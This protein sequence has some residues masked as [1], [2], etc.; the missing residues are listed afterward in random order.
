MEGMVCVVMALPL[1]LPLGCLGGVVGCSIAR[2]DQRSRTAWVASIVMLPGG[3]AVEHLTSLPTEHCVTTEIVVTATPETVWRNVIR[4]PDLPPPTEAMFRAGISCPMGAAIT[5]TGVGAE[6]RCLFTTG[7]F[8][9]PIT[10]WD[11]P[12]HLAFDV[13]SQPEPMFEMTPFRHVHPPHLK[14]SF[15]STRGEFRLLP[16]VDGRTRLIGRTWYRLKLEP[17]W[18]W[19]A[20]S[21]QIIHAI[22]GR[23]LEHIK[24][25]SEDSPQESTALAQ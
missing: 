25:L 10:V 6:R 15:V 22:H 18:Y 12:R 13:E 23:V 21:S 4:F 5:G 20:L 14:E 17:A 19:S 16:M 7:E 8:V 9:E 1:V 3:T 2:L 11:E 24:T